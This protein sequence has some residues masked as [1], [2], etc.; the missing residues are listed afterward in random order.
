MSN[1][2]IAAGISLLITGMVLLLFFSMRGF[3]AS[4]SKR[5]RSYMDPLPPQVKVIWPLVRLVAGQVERMLTVEYVER[6]RVNMERSGLSFMYAPEEFVSLKIIC[7]LLATIVGGI[8]LSMTKY[9]LF[10][11]LIIIGV[12]GYFMPSISMK[13]RREKRAKEIIRMLPIYLDFITMSVEAGLSL[14]AA[15]AQ[16]TKKGPPGLLRLELDRANRDVK[17][18]AGRIEALQSMAERLDI[19]EITTLVNSLAQADKTGASIGNVLRLQAD[20]RL[21]ERFQRA[22]KLAMEAPVK[23]IFPLVMFIFPCT[24]VV[25]GFP[26]AMKFLHGM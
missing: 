14:G 21:I 1:N 10:P 5:D 3:G 23:L 11:W 15:L 26:I 2:F 6:L 19:R 25:L 17:A 13:E 8:G 9:G 24:F 18:G 22:E 4:A 20:Q 7:A 12:F 16:A